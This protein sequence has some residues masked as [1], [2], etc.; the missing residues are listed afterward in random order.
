MRRFLGSRATIVVLLLSILVLVIGVSVVKGSGSGSTSSA[1]LGRVPS[2]ETVPVTVVAEGCKGTAKFDVYA[3]GFEKGD[4]VLITLR[5]VSG[6]VFIGS[7]FPN[8]T[9]GFHDAVEVT[10]ADCGV[11]TVQ[12]KRKNDIVT[13]PVA[14][15]ASK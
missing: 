1:S 12:A 7:G 10:V 4:V 8:E 5:T 14:I 15:V 13:A 9:G 2:L 6:Q 3:A 11:L